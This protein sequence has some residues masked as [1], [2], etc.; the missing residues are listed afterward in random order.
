MKVDIHHIRFKTRLSQGSIDRELI[1]PRIAVDVGCP[2]LGSLTDPRFPVVT[3][4]HPSP[5][6]LLL[7]QIGKPVRVVVQL[8]PNPAPIVQTGLRHFE[9]LVEHGPRK[10]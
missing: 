7:K 6:G 9:E 3:Y 10:L 5:V 8:L 2:H 4:Q 1:T